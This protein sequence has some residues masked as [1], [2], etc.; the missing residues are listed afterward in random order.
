MAADVEITSLS[1][2]SLI[3]LSHCCFPGTEPIFQGGQFCHSAKL[4]QICWCKL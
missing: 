2:I 1:F 3:L 4:Q